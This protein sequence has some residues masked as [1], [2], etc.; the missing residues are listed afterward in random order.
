MSAH[1]YIVQ[2]ALMI[3]MANT[4]VRAHSASAPRDGHAGRRKTPTRQRKSRSTM[5][6][7]RKTSPESK[8][9]LDHDLV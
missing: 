4:T 6:A 2:I 9:R 3:D 5:V 1:C 7:A 8:Q